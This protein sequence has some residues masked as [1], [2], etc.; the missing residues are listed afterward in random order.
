M[1]VFVTKDRPL[2]VEVSDQAHP[3]LALIPQNGRLRTTLVASMFIWRVAFCDR[4]ER[5][6]VTNAVIH[7]IAHRCQTIA[8]PFDGFFDYVSAG[9]D[10][11]PNRFM[12]RENWDRHATRE[13]VGGELSISDLIQFVGFLAVFPRSEDFRVLFFGGTR[14]QREHATVVIDLNLSRKW[15]DVCRCRS[16]H[17]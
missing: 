9:V 11:L 4:R 8:V 1:P 10:S 7:L 14:E 15:T 17:L 12:F 6:S 2:W 16:R 13:L 5:A 3:E